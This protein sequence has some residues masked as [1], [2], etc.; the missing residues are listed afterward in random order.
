[1]M[2]SEIRDYSTGGKV[3]FKAFDELP[4]MVN[5]TP[6]YRTIAM[7]LVKVDHEGSVVRLKSDHKHKN[8]LGT[9]HGGALASLA[10]SA[11][12]LSL[13]PYLKEGETMITIS[14]HVDYIATGSK[15]DLTGQGKVIHRGRRLIRAEAV[16]TDEEE[17]LIAKGYAT[18]INTSLHEYRTNEDP[19]D[20]MA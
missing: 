2:V 12:S 15:G 6:F 17:R 9:I 18:L 5:K 13:A 11:C 1:M 7:E 14:L 20:P 19:E 16:I 4:A 8:I 10:D 3:M